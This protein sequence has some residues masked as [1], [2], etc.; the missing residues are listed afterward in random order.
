MT[1]R[2][3]TVAVIL[4]AAVLASAAAVGVTAAAKPDST[5]STFHGPGRFGPGPGGPPPAQQ[6]PRQSPTTPPTQIR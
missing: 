5:R 4:G 3:R 6:Q 1:E 2:A